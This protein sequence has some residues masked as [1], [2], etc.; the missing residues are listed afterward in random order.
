MNN[1]S[2]NTVGQTQNEPPASPTAPQVHLLHDALDSFAPARKS[3][4]FV[5]IPG[6]LLFALSLFIA[7]LG[8]SLALVASPPVA[9]TVV[10]RTHPQANE[11]QQKAL[12][13]IGLHTLRYV[14]ALPFESASYPQPDPL[15]L[16]A[17]S[18]PTYTSQELSHLRDVRMTIGWTLLATFSLTV[19][20]V[21]LIS[22]CRKS[23][24][25]KTGLLAGGIVCLAIPAVVAAALTFFFDPTFELFHR[26]LYPQGNWMFPAESLLISV[27]PASYWSTMGLLWMGA[28]ALGGIICVV[29]SRFCGKN[30][31]WH[32]TKR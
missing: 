22:F 5:H 31:L 8:L 30:R 1:Y 14:T 28:L 19:I 9:L 2:I 21:A 26:L 3:H 16:D 15:N 13:T 24:F 18:R 12:T 17:L 29:F 27:F 11:L 23:H 10:T 4:P 20:D 25:V 32:V 7:C 6:A